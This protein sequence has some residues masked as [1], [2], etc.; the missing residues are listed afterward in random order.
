MFLAGTCFIKLNL[1]LRVLS[2]RK[3]GYHDIFSLFWR[4][5]SPEVVEADFDSGRDSLEVSGADIPGENILTRVCRH[6]RSVY[7]GDSL[8]PVSIRL[9]KHIPTGSGVGAG[10]G[11][12]AAF[13]QIFRALRGKGPAPGVSSLGADVAFLASGHSLAFASGIGDILEGLS[14]DL[15]LAAAVFFPEWS[16]GTSSA[17]DALDEMRARGDAGALSAHEAREETV[18]VLGLL[19]RGE[20]AGM[21]PNDFIHCAGHDDKYAALRGAA[22]IAG[23]LAWGLCGSGGAFFALFAPEDASVRMSAMFEAIR[24]KD[25]KEK[26]QWLQQILVLE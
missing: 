14:G 11:N 13:L 21:L 5:R 10:S 8:P 25:G 17:Y 12:A 1:T 18:S 16:V 26:F 7:G 15:R 9:R 2:R 20:R 24:E 4:L 22:D 6:I 3:D 23:A 19:R